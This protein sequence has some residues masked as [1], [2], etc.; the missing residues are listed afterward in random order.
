MALITIR[1]PRGRA[2]DLT[3]TKAENRDGPPLFS[4]DTYVCNGCSRETVHLVRMASFRPT[5]SEKT[6]IVTGLPELCLL[7]GLDQ[8][9]PFSV[10]SAVF[11]GGQNIVSGYV[12]KS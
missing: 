9:A 11:K 3:V 1:I 6:F 7:L 10:G 8:R 2:A 12:G 4:T 5:L